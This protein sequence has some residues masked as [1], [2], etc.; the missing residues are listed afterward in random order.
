M[1]VSLEVQRFL[2]RARSR[3]SPAE[4]GISEL[5]GDRR[6]PGLRREEV[7]ALA[8]VS[9]TY[10][11]RIERGR[12][13]G[14]SE[15]VLRAI[16][17]ALRMS[18]AESQHLLNLAR[19][20]SSGGRPSRRMSTTRMDNGIERLLTTMA[21][22]PAIALG[23]LGDPLGANALGRSLFPH[24]FPDGRPPINHAHYVFLDQ[25]ARTFYVD[26]ERSARRVVSVLRLLAGQD[27]RDHA[28]TSLV[29][30]LS[31][32]SA[33][34]RKE[35]AG[36]AVDTHAAGSKS[37]RHPTVGEMTL[38]FE[39]LSVGSAPDVRIG[40]YLAVE[41]T[42]SADALNVLRSGMA[43]GSAASGVNAAGH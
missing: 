2:T 7:A 6:V 24:L 10:Y 32:R 31:A 9:I 3:L 39:T 19:A 23:R 1:D 25:R 21:D 5:G 38:E 15:S 40:T 35:W 11:I 43:M 14:V 41:G 33:D 18:D 36:H 20:D 13:K 17:R 42:P 22:V 26:W 37:I 4:V 29:N 34:F 27:P 30:D 28:L 12:L 8:G 16:A